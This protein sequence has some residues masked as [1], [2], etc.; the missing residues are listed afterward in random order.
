MTPTLLDR[1]RARLFRLAFS[2]YPSFWSTGATLASLAPDFSAA[3]VELPLTWRTRNGMGTLFGGSMYGAVDPVYVVLLQRRLG[4]G[5]TVWDRAAE[6]RFRKP[7]RSTLY[8]TFEVPDAE[9]R[10][11]R[12]SLDPGESCDR[13]YDV[14]LVDSEGTVHAEVEKTVYV[15]RDE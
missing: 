5:F 10:E 12:E 2:Y 15:R 9:I 8:A 11:I 3:E 13:V 14:D 7:G 4:D 6:I 1:L